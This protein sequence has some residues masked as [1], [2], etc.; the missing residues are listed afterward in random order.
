MKR[1]IT[2]VF[3]AL[4][5]SLAFAA[6]TVEVTATDPSDGVISDDECAT[7][8]WKIETDAGE[9]GSWRVEIEGDCIPGEG[10]LIDNGSFSGNKT[11]N[12]EICADD[13]DDGDGD[14]TVCV[15][16]IY[17][18]GE[19][20]YTYA[21]TT[22]K[23]DNPPQK[24]EG[25]SVGSGEERLFL[26]WDE[27]KDKDIEKVYIGYDT[28]SHPDATKIEDYAGTGAKKGNS[29]ISTD[30]K[31]N[32]YIL[33]GLENGTKYYI[34]IVFEDE[35]GTIGDLSNEKS[36]TPHEVSGLVDLTEEEGGCFVATTL[37]G[38]D[39]FATRTL[40]TFR[41]KFL[42][43]FD[44]T[45]KLVKLYYKHGPKIARYVSAKPVLTVVIAASLMS[46]ALVI[47][48]VVGTTSS[49]PYIISLVMIGAIIFTIVSRRRR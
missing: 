35:E 30:Y 34:R 8:Y 16:A 39:H 46:F 48:P 25:F 45:C 13:L 33:K 2:V 42:V 14:Y 37:F 22:I 20:E 31:D 18:A 44:T 5:A 49:L 7:V 15:I 23:L 27:P 47:A 24:P 11:G 19:E 21:S 17:G 9:S 40:R 1:L 36:Q 43:K 29:P 4:I 28:E 38:E 3:I 6:V 26:K 41:D 10:D 12:T 32:E